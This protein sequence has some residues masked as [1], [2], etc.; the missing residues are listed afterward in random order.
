MTTEGLFRAFGGR[1]YV[2]A[3]TGV[4]RNAINHWLRNGVPYRHWPAIREAARE[5]G[6]PGITDLALASTRPG[7]PRRTRRRVAAE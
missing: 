5:A 7:V 2:M 6:I 3:V 4:S 1:E